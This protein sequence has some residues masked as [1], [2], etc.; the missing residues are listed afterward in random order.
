LLGILR[1]HEFCLKPINL[2]A[3]SEYTRVYKSVWEQFA[4]N[5]SRP[6][7]YMIFDGSLL[8]HPI[9]DMINNY[10]ISGEQAVSHVNK[11]IEAVNILSPQVIYLSSNN[12]AE[13]L[14]KAQLSRKKQPPSAE[15]I[16]FWEKRKK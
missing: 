2:V 14:R 10:N 13:R 16:Q 12:V 5:V 15:R 3:L 8:H 1:K 11:L 7:D 9:N 4:K 6:L